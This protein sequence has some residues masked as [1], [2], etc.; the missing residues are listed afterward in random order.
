[1]SDYIVKNVPY[2]PQKTYETCWLAAYKK[3]AQGNYP[4]MAELIEKTKAAKLD[5][6]DLQAGFFIRDEA[7]SRADVALV[8]EAGLNLYA[9]T[10]D[11]ADVARRLEAL[12]LDGI[13]TNRPAWLREQLAAPVAK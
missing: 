13:T 7:A 11:D 12:G 8:R 6:L 2:I 4:A 1:M 5:G 9:W 10:V 3:D